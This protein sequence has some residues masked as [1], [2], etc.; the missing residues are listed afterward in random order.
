MRYL[1]SKN[2]M[3]FCINNYKDTSDIV[4]HLDELEKYKDNH[5]Y[6]K[7]DIENLQAICYCESEGVTYNLFEGPDHEIWY[8]ISY[9]KTPCIGWYAC[10]YEK[11][12]KR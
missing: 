5:C 9:T 1:P 4:S 6:I 2:Q 7:M 11:D 12:Y 3:I 8:V 10:Q